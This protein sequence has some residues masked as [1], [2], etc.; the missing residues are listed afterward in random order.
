MLESC[1]CQAQDMLVFKMMSKYFFF[2][3]LLYYFTLQENEEK[4][5]GY[6]S[7]TF[8]SVFR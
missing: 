2:F 7:V 1:W 8:L 5:V 6:V 3:F 4:N